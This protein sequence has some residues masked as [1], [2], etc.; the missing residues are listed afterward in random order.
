MRAVLTWLSIVPFIPGMIYT[1]SADNFLQM[2]AGC[3]LLLMSAVLVVGA[4]IVDELIRIRTVQ[5][6]IWDRSNA[7]HQA[8]KP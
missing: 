4:A 6:G 2:I 5:E 7:H 3:V 1:V 8:P